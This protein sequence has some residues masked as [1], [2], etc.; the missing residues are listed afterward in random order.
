MRVA[1][2]CL[3][4]FLRIAAAY[5]ASDKQAFE[6]IARGRYLALAGDCAGCHSA[7]GSAPYAGGLPIETPFGTLVSPNITPDRE[8]GIG[9]WTDDEFLNAMQS[10]IGRGGEH[11][12]PAMPYTYYTKASREDVLAIRAYLETVNPVHNEIKANQLPFPFDIRTSM[13]GWNE[14]FFKRGVFRSVVGKSD[15]WN[16][17]AYLVE[18]LG[19][20]GLCHTAKNAMGGDETTRALQGS[21]LQGWYAPNLTGDLRTGLGGWPVEE[22]VAY[23]KMGH[24]NV[25]AATGPMSD[26][27]VH[28]TS[29][30]TE[31]DLRAIAVYLKDQPAPSGEPP[32]PVSG[33]DRL[34]RAGE[35]LY[36][37]N[38]AACHISTGNGIPQLFPALK[39]SPSVQSADPASLIRVVLRGARSVAT[40][41]AIT[42]PVMPA[43]GW[44]LSD[45]DVAAVITYIRNSWGNAASPI[46]ADDVG[47]A[48]R[49][50]SRRTD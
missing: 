33:E 32:K 29:Q 12:Y 50:L 37:D 43:F 36:V 24:N 19:H 14:L 40:D 4:L 31:T 34:M 8:T 35:A 3:L 16:R 1:A 49:Q 20:C 26:V 2:A 47:S 10:G 38:C 42:G 41:H 39:N 9:A 23:L 15:E 13:A 46:S 22:I 17:G 18:G 11:L 48:R 28:S 25:S 21:A 5:A 30:M 44:K 27:I 7:P 45:T 6:E